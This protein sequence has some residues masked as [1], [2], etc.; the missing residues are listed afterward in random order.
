MT[1]PT[2][3]VPGQYRFAKLPT[4]ELLL[5]IAELACVQPSI[6]ANQARTKPVV[7]ID[8]NV[9]L[10]LLY[11]HDKDAQ[12]LNQRIERREYVICI[13]LACLEE[14]ADVISRTHFALDEKQQHAI[15][16]EVLQITTLICAPESSSARCR[17]TDDQKFLDLAQAVGA[18]FLITKDKL[19]LKAGKKL[20]KAGVMTL[21]PEKVTR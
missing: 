7:V 4:A 5:S 21:T 11:W 9:W 10:D 6:V 19:V 14:L 18:D 20:K 16:N 1:N 8:T 3:D 15:L 2:V 17:D 12:E 13:T